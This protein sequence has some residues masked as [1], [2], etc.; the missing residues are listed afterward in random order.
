MIASLSRNILWT[1]FSIIYKNHF[2]KQN[3]ILNSALSR[4]MFLI[5]NI[6]RKALLLNIKI[7]VLI[8]KQ[9]FSVNVKWSSRKI[10]GS[11][12][13]IQIN[14]IESIDVI[15]SCDNWLILMNLADQSLTKYVSTKYSN[16][17]S[18]HL[19]CVLFNCAQYGLRNIPKKIWKFLWYRKK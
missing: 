15:K 17:W 14:H 16:D 19:S 5:I 9:N 12:K 18:F 10:I 11:N 6:K 4:M 8:I 7:K 2:E 1:F 13:H 3:K